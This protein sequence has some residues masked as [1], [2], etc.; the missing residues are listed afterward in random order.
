MQRESSLL[1]AFSA[2][3]LVAAAQGFG[4]DTTAPAV[5]GGQWR[6]G[7]DQLHQNNGTPR[8]TRQRIAVTP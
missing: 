1:G 8:L 6:L 4:P 3:S 5:S 7:R 2:L